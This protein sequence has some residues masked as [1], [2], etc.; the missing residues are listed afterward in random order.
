MESVEEALAGR[1]S[2]EDANTSLESEG[3]L[4]SLEEELRTTREQRRRLETKGRGELA[5]EVKTEVKSSKTKDEPK[6]KKV[7]RDAI[8]RTV[9]KEKQIKVEVDETSVESEEEHAT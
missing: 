5:S 6:T 9:I 1:S 3:E 8:R 2:T 4:M 7:K